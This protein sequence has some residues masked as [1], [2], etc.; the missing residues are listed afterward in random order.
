M[1]DEQRSELLKWLRNGMTLDIAARLSDL[2]PGD[3][4]EQQHG[5]VELAEQIAKALAEGEAVHL[6]RIAEA[7]RSNWR[8]S[9]WILERLYPEKYAP[10]L[11]QVPD[12]S[13]LPTSLDDFPG[14]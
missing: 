14:L 13:P 12:A 6:A 4:A 9:A 1:E 11:P 7:G 5:D 2:S 10:P 3:V 8:A